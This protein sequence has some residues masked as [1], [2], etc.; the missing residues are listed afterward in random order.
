MQTKQYAANSIR[1]YMRT[2][3]YAHWFSFISVYVLCC[4]LFFFPFLFLKYAQQQTQSTKQ[5]TSNKISTKSTKKRLNS[6]E[7]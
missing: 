6:F 2:H 1:L 7:Y 5:T 3:T 4:F